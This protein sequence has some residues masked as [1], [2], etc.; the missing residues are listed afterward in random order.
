MAPNSGEQPLVLDSSSTPRKRTKVVSAWLLANKNVSDADLDYAVTVL[1]VDET[2][3]RS[4]RSGLLS[5]AAVALALAAVVAAMM[6]MQ[7]LEQTGLV[8]GWL[9]VGCLVATLICIAGILFGSWKG[10]GRHKTRLLL[11]DRR[12]RNAHARAVAV[13]LADAEQMR[14]ATESPVRAWRFVRVRGRTR[15][16]Q[17]YL[18]PER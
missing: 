13:E 2:S 7:E 16:G 9:I 8:V 1:E 6:Q 15:Q 10:R 12:R 17:V 4:D 18:A 11:L 3:S 5:M 14:Q